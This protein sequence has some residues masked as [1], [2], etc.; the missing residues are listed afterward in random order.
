[1]TDTDTDVR[2]KD[3]IRD[4]EIHVR[5]EI[6]VRTIERLLLRKWWRPAGNSARFWKKVGEEDPFKPPK[7]NRLL[8]NNRPTK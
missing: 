6:G 5:P 2:A 1:M 7:H 3:L 8:E 4:G